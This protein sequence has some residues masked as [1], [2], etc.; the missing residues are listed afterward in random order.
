MSWPVLVPWPGPPQV[1]VRCD[2]L[3][4]AV[5]DVFV[6]DEPSASGQVPVGPSQAWLRQAVF[7]ARAAARPLLGFPS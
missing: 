2:D 1:C 3:L 7:P 4:E 5:G 6:P